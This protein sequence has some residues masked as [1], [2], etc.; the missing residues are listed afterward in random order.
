[1]TALTR[2]SFLALTGAYD[3]AIAVQTQVVE[4]LPNE[5]KYKKALKAFQAKRAMVPTPSAK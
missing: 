4:K 5:P 1:M 3:E 2:R